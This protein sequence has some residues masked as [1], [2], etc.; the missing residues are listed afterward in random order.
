MSVATTDPILLDLDESTWNMQ[1]DR[2][3]AWM[4]NAIMTQEKFRK[5]AEDT[6]SKIREP[7][8]KRYLE[9][10]AARAGANEELAR[11][12]TRVLG[13]D[14]SRSRSLVGAVLAQGAELVADAI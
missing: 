14:P 3:A 5:F 11:G 12:L 4:N 2:A 10:I 9:E 8:I 1:L 7:H 13:R 6:A